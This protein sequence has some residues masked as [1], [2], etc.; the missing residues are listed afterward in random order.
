ML[1]PLCSVPRTRWT[2]FVGFGI[3]KVALGLGSHHQHYNELY[4]LFSVHGSD[5]LDWGMTRQ[6]CLLVF[7]SNYNVQGPSDRAKGMDTSMSLT[8]FAWL[9]NWNQSAS[10]WGHRGFQG[11]PMGWD[12][13]IMASS[14][15]F[16]EWDDKATSGLSWIIHGHKNIKNITSKASIL[17]YFHVM[18]T[19]VFCK[20]TWHVYDLEQK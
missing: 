2:T 14:K 15:L 18:L 1:A 19:I 3:F 20:F 5:L 16:C 12:C 13:S 10:G 7:N 9:T 4:R 11:L 6:S 17:C 8:I